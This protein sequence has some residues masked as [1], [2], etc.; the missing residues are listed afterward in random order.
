VI[1]HLPQELRERFTEMREMDLQVQNSMDMLE[2]RVKFLFNNA[3][4]SK[5]EDRDKEF[6]EI[7]KGY[8][9]SLEDAGGYYRFRKPAKSRRYFNGRRRYS[10]ES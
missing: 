7:R 10:V 4:K 2:K 1:E 5:E 9:K 6:Q 3:L 8:M